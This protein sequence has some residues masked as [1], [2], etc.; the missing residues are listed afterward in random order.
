MPAMPRVPTVPQ[1]PKLPSGGAKV[2]IPMII[3]GLI[4][5][6]CWYLKVDQRTTV[7]YI[8]L[9]V[10]FWLLILGIQKLLAIRAAKKIER[11]LREQAEAQLRAAGGESKSEIEALNQKFNEA[12]A[13]LKASRMGKS[14][15]Y[16]LP[17]YVIIG[18]PGS[19]KTTC[20]Q[21][22]GLNFPAMGSNPSS[23]RGV[24][25]TRNCD[26]WFT[27]EAIFLDTAGR[28]TTDTD[29]LDEWAS[30]LDLVRKTRTHTPLNGAI[31][32]V[33]VQDLIV[34]GEDDIAAY[35]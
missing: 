20:I 23:V 7:L 21:E 25:G 15:L 27:D 32:V 9:G 2:I 26:W 5:G 30:F 29:D 3:V 1:M 17:W 28:Y 14:A 10:V 12:L 8:M 16:T 18:A 34:M 13:M 35:A 31:V 11:Q 19:G 4:Y 22:S 24:G 33:S 6:V